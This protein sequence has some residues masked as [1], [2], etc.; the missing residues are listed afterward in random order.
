MPVTS[1]PGVL[2]IA[3]LGAGTVGSAVV[4]VLV[5]RAGSLRPADGVALELGAVATRDLAAATERGVPGDLLTDAP[6]HL[7]ASDDTDVIVEVMGGEEP[8][9]TLIVAALEAGKAVVTANKHVIAR[10]GPLLE[11]IARRTGAPL[12]FEAAVGSGIPIL[13]TMAESLAGNVIHRVRGVVNGTTNHILT[14]MAEDG[15]PYAD[16]LDDAQARGY[17]EADPRADVE[18][19]DAA[20]KLVILA[21]LAYGTWLDPD[22]ILRRPPTV[23]GDGA[24]GITGVTDAEVDGAEALGFSMRL[25]AGAVRTEGGDI[26]AAVLPTA[27]PAASP[28]GWTTGVTNRIEIDGTPIGTIRVAGPGAGGDPTASAIIG[29]LLAIARGGGSTWA[30]LAPATGGEGG[31]VAAVPG[32]AHA[33]DWYVHLRGVDAADLPSELA[34]AAAVEIAGGLAVHLSGYLLDDARA[35]VL[36]ALPPEAD[37]TLYPIDD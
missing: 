17:A 10:H 11:E 22:T 36:P 6:A 35:A 5:D 37:A 20:H 31:A 12:R 9:R 27:V 23:R 32:T 28:F 19:D 7:V 33:R 3:V 13:S 2:R 14:A 1:P 4:R 25:L 18:G 8:A 29:D 34:E 24:P 16:A 30:G 26:A 21:R 15:L